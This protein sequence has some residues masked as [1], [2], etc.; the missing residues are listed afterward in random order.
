MV[1]SFLVKRIKSF[2][3]RIEPLK[4]KQKTIIPQRLEAHLKRE[5]TFQAL[6]EADQ[7]ALLKSAN[8]PESQQPL[9][10]ATQPALHAVPS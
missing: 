7:R 6:T 9:F 1:S 5:H 8:T 10:P 4:G 3:I 2:P